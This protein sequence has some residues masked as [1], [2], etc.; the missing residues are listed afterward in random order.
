ME[1]DANA[2][3]IGE[4]YFGAARNVPNFIYLSAGSGI[5]GGLVVNGSLFRGR[6]GYAGEIGHMA[7]DPDGEIC[8]C[9]KTGLL[10]N[11][12][13]AARSN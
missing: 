5:G 9:G 8:S 12:G 2:A 1:N 7:I 6:G 3:A 10:G 11:S 13:W 4:Y